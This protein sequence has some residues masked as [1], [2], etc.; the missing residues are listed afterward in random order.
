MEKVKIGI[1]GL[2]RMGKHH[3]E[4]VKYSIR[5]AELVAVCCGNLQRAHEMQGQLETRYAYT[6]Y[7]EMLENSEVDAV[8]ISSA[9]EKHCEQVIKA[10][11][12]RKHVFCEKPL[13]FTAEECIK[14]NE[15]LQK[16]PGIVVQIGFMTRYDKA[17]L[18]AKDII[19]NGGIGEP[20]YFRSYR[21][22]G[23]EHIQSSIDFADRSGGI[24]FDVA[25]HDFDLARWLLEDEVESVYAL[26]G[27]Y[28]YKEF[29]QASDCD[30]GMVTLKFQSGTMGT[31]LC[32]RISPRGFHVE[33][34]VIGTHGTVHV[35][36]RNGQ[37]EV[38]VYQKGKMNQRFDGWFNDRFREAF[39]NE[40]QH[41][42]D[43]VLQ[44][45]DA[46]VTVQDAIMATKVAE[47]ATK[48]YKE[49]EVKVLNKVK[50]WG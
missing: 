40:K 39:I 28:R 34:E 3:A 1:V 21:I 33:T 4:D 36:S 45:T 16:T 27:C 41:F 50:D 26:G 24:F 2:G 9:S 44:G 25:T 13:G 8:I 35:G 22:D 10:I 47:L 15:I 17:Y 12:K 19:L 5:N 42:I 31:I 18:Q 38:Y 32:G 49:K 30:S 46:E 11:E 37:P 20:V 43:S 29:E 6:D 23:V 7:E 48:S 14:V